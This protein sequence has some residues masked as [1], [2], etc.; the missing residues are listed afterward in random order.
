MDKEKISSFFK[1]CGEWIQR[2]GR[3]LTGLIVFV[4]GLILIAKSIMFIANMIVFL[5]GLML[6]YYSLRLLNLYTVT[7]TVDGFLNKMRNHFFR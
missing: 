7:N 1:S 3:T 2:H 4:V 6:L 5:A